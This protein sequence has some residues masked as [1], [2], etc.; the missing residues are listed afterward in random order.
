MARGA[1]DPIR[2]LG[3]Q[4]RLIGAASLAEEFGIEP[5]YL[6]QGIAAALCYNNPEDKEAVRL[7]GKL[8]DE[9]VDAVLKNICNLEPEGKLTFLIKEKLEEINTFKVR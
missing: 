9:G 2:K 5:Q 8:K 6:A 3:P 4:D 7:S 1:K